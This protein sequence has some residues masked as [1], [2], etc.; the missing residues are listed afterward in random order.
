MTST[1][2]YPR[3]VVLAI[4]FILLF[5]GGTWKN[6]LSQDGEQSNQLAPLLKNMGE[7]EHHISTDS[8]KAQTFFNQ[9][10]NL[11]YGFN[12]GEAK[13]SFLEAARRD[14]ECAMPYWGAALVLGPNINATMSKQRT[15][16]AW[17]YLQKAKSR[18]KNATQKEK[19]YIKAL[20]KRYAKPPVNN[21]EKLDRAYARA[22]KK[23]AEKYSKDPDAKVL[24]GEAVMNLHPWN[25][26]T[27]AGEPREKTSSMLA[28]F[29]S[30]LEN[31]PNHP[32]ANHLYIHAVESQHPK[33]ALPSARR[34]RNRRSGTGHLLHMPS[35]VFLRIGRYHEASETNEE[36]IKADN[37]YW[38]LCKQNGY[39]VP[40]TYPLTYRPHNHHFIAYT[41]MMEGRS[42]RAIIGAR[43]LKKLTDRQ[44]MRQK[45]WGTL[46]HF[47]TIELYT[48][49]SFGRWNQIKNDPKPPEDL[50]YPRAV[51]RYARTMAHLRTGNRKKATTEFKEL[52]VLQKHPELKKTGIFKIGPIKQLVDIAVL[53]TKGERA[54]ARSNYDQALEYLKNATKKEDDLGYGDPPTWPKP[55][56]HNYGA[57]ALEAGKPKR[58]EQIYREDLNQFPNN[59]W[60]LYGLAEALRRQGKSEEAE[61]IDGRFK[62]AWKH[63]DVTLSS[64]RF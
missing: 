48:M 26:W 60:S 17:R 50:I 9:G 31:H 40:G 4:G 5:L 62:N 46:Q 61:K 20:E 25:Y 14:P 41:A 7:W 19:D 27:D 23:L 54:A 34:L 57:I 18:M 43:T 32:G 51:W 28:A 36:A 10:L 1:E 3:W 53:I 45:G 2:Q 47:Y 58:A 39:S 11:A 30:V 16:E 12:F 13:R 52:L 24:Y 37:K 56:R 42:Y 55:V 6:S 22:M 15:R 29:K 35:H 21:R 33:R 44:V 49:V 63:A 38:A 8:K 59:G 64:S